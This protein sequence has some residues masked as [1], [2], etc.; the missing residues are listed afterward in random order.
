MERSKKIVRISA[1]GVAVNLLMAGLK[2]VL[3]LI[4][5]SV[6]ILMDGV[7]NLSD[8]L[9]SVITIVG[10]KLSNKAPDKKHPYGYGR[11]ENIASVTVSLMVL[12]AGLTSLRESGKAVLH[13][14]E[15]T[16]T[17]LSLALVAGAVVVKLLLGWYVKSAGKRYNSDAL[18]ASGTESLFDSLI[19]LSTLVAAG[20]SVMTGVFIEGWL[21]LVISLV[22]LRAGVK[23]LMES[24]G[25]VIGARVDRALSLKLKAAIREYPHVLG[26]YDLALHRYGPDRTIGSV[27]VEL[28]DYVTAKEIHRLTQDI[29][30]DVMQDFNIILTVGI[31]ASNT[32]EASQ[33]MKQKL[34]T[35]IADY[36]DILQMHG[37]YLDEER[38]EVSFDLVIDF[39]SQVRV[40]LRDTVIALMTQAYPGYTFRITLDSDYSD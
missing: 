15:T 24:L 23:L 22:I 27:H 5:A 12:V 33:R 13:P 19:S 28:A 6:A 25:G 16:Y 32:D 34:Q 17:A 10:T 30:R 3:G 38:K 4:T 29:T 8:A 40:Q 21:G 1:V 35:I 39:A 20:I 26:A 31:Y 9:S 11:V 7:N 37:F 36:D 2:V 18:I 14:V